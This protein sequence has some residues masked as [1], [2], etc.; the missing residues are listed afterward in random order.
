M[1]PAFA[2]VDSA[3]NSASSVQFGKESHQLRPVEYQRGT[4]ARCRVHTLGHEEREFIQYQDEPAQMPSGAVGKNGFL[5]LGFERRGQRTIL[6]QLERRTPLLA[7]KALYWDTTMPD[8]ACVFI[9]MTSG[10]ILGGD[11]LAIEVDVAEGARAHVTTQAAT[12][13][14]SMDANFAAQVQHIRV[15]ANAYLEFL[16]DTVIPHRGSRFLTETKITIAPSAT[17]LYSEILMPGRKHHRK[18][19]SF[20]WDL[21]SSRVSA[22]R[23]D[24]APLFTEKLLIEPRHRNVRQ[25]GV[26]NSWDV[27]GNV[28]L[29]TPKSNADRILQQ[30]GAGATDRLAFGAARL[31]NESGIAFKV[32]GMESH[33]V[34]KK[35]H[36]FWGMT[37]EAVAGIPAPAGWFWR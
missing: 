6:A 3:P 35:V 26:M 7:Q 10:C 29:L 23:E 25:T 13:I 11:R 21:F 1:N 36:E 12:K 27:F 2:V 5:H 22:V 16:P 18:D 24:D 31:P 4:D 20:G 19:E 17:L 37:R 8:M 28:L 15:R 32:L 33:D 14:H 9:I 34:K 30:T